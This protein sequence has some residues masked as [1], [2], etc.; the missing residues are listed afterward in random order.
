MLMV[1]VPHT[2]S[3]N[4]FSEPLEA[5]FRNISLGN[6]FEEVL[7]ITN[8]DVGIGGLGIRLIIKY[9]HKFIPQ[10]GGY[11][12][13]VGF[14]D[15]YWEGMDIF[16]EN[17]WPIAYLEIELGKET[18][19]ICKRYL[20]KVEKFLSRYQEGFCSEVEPSDEKFRQIQMGF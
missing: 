10:E 1:S 4:D 18:G 16:G 13:Y 14:V 20:F 15:L 5:V 8:G 6:T 3:G 17:A 12:P 2:V 11:E 9:R 19:V 7:K